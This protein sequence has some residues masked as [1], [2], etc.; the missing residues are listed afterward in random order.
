VFDYFGRSGVEK[1]I[2]TKTQERGKVEKRTISAFRRMER[3]R[4]VIPIEGGLQGSQ[5]GEKDRSDS[6]KSSI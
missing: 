6:P 2:K 1:I 3:R 5:Q 4:S